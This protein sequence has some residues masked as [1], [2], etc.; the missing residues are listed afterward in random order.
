MVRLGVGGSLFLAGS[1]GLM[2]LLE[3]H[4]YVLGVVGIVLVCT[5]VMTLLLESELRR[6]Y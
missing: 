4:E 6:A 1:F 5:A 3:G 2:F